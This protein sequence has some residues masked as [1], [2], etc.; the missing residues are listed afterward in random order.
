MESELQ[1]EFGPERA[2]NGV[3]RRLADTSAATHHL[4]FTAEI[5]LEDGLRRLVAWWRAEQGALVS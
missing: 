4:G 5:G 3:T 2:V 1:V